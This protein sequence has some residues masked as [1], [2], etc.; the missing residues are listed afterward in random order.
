VLVDDVLL[1]MG[2]KKKQT[3]LH[4]FPNLT[5][6]TIISISFDLWMFRDGVDIFALVTNFLNH[7]WTP[8]HVNVDLFKVKETSG[9]SMEI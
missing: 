3:N 6:V 8:M 2:K 1:A 5:F 7:S 4:V 9:W